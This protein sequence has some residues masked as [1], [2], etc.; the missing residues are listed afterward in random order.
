MATYGIQAITPTIVTLDTA[1]SPY[2]VVHTVPSGKEQTILLMRA[3]NKSGADTTI[4]VGIRLPGGAVGSEKWV[5][6]NAPL[7]TASVANA[8][9]PDALGP[10]PAGT[11]IIARASTATAV[12]L[13]ITGTERTI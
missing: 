13:V 5:S 6:F 2:P 4:S 8:F 10:L 12:D 3:T 9:G 7:K 1:T 11:A